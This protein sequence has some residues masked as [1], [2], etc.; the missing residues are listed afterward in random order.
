MLK[1]SL[2]NFTINH[3]KIHAHALYLFLFF[4]RGM[5]AQYTYCLVMAKIGH[6][7][8]NNIYVGYARHNT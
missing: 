5:H 7:M 3:G 2:L 1:R 8:S 4:L 6:Q